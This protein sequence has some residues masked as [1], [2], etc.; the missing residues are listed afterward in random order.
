MEKWL[1]LVQSHDSQDQVRIMLEYFASLS[2]SGQELK[3]KEAP[4]QWV[5]EGHAEKWHR[6][7]ESISVNDMVNLRI[8][9]PMGIEK[10]DKMNPD[11]LRDLSY[12]CECDIFFHSPH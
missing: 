2:K 9:E 4:L 11:F 12:S 10:P 7:V 1:L 3:C 6:Q 5:M 8:Q